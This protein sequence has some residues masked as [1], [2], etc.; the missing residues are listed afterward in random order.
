MQPVVSD[1]H[2]SHLYVSNLFSPFSHTISDFLPLSAPSVA[3]VACSR[4]QVTRPARTHL[5]R[6]FSLRKLPEITLLVSTHS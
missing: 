3:S 4:P 1:C 2:L 6:L 5:F